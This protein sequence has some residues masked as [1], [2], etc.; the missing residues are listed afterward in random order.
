MLVGCHEGVATVTIERTA[1]R[2]AL[3]RADM[4]RAGADVP[5]AFAAFLAK[6]P[7]VFTG[8]HRR[9]TSGGDRR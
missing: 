4:R 7:P 5:E 8:G 9:P 3:D 6:R 2:N 1:K